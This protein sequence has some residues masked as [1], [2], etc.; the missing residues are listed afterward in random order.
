MKKAPSRIVLY[1]KDVERI[2]GR[3]PRTCYTILEKIR[4]FYKKPKHAFVTI[5]E[6]SA[7]LGIEEE[8]VREYMEG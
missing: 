6:F 2:T 4:R 1:A 8:L 7:F 5:R 3:R